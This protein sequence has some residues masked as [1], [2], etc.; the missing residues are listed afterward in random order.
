MLPQYNHTTNAITSERFCT[1]RLL[2][3]LGVFSSIGVDANDVAG[4]DEERDIHLR[5]G[6]EL[7]ELGAARDGVA[8]DC[9]GSIFDHKIDFDWDLDGHRFLFVG[10][11]FD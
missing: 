2:H 6:R 8:L 7:D 1:L 10:E 5:P 9:W 3:S 4:V 11:Y